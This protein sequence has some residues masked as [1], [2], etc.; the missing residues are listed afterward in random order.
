METKDQIYEIRKKE[1]DKIAEGD[2]ELYQELIKQ[3]IKELKI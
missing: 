2:V 1:I 3:L